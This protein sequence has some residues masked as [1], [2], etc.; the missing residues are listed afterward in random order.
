[1]VILDPE[2]HSLMAVQWAVRE[3]SNSG[4]SIWSCSLWHDFGHKT[5]IFEAVAWTGGWNIL[6]TRQCN[7]VVVDSA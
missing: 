1:M 7:L 5:Q 3:R 2:W 4:R 6:G